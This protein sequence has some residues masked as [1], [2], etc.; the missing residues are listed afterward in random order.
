[1]VLKG[2][3]V[4]SGVARGRAHVLLTRHDLAVQRRAI[5]PGEVDA[6]ID[7]FESALVQAESD[8][9]ALQ[10]TLTGQ[11]GAREAEIFAA[12]AL[13][14]RSTQLVDPVKTAVRQLRINAEAA[15]SEVLQQL[16]QTFD[17]LANAYL[18]ER[19]ADVRDVG[20]RVLALLV[21]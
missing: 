10:K 13:L 17:A 8:L 2:I 15:L 21:A 5:A 18:R 9:L 1:M 20:K 16:V 14:V 7:R 11:I 12:Q 19:A 6:E 3:A 4:S